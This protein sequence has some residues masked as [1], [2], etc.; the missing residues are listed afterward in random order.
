MYGTGINLSR[1]TLEDGRVFPS[2]EGKPLAWDFFL[3]D[4]WE[5]EKQGYPRAKA[6]LCE[7]SDDELRA[8]YRTYLKASFNQM[9]G[10]AAGK[11]LV[12]IEAEMNRRSEEHEEFRM[13][14]SHK[15][16]GNR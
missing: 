12:L 16:R 9:F 4:S 13:T 2:Y 10:H 11:M 5:E 15:D 1:V 8:S 3:Y 7:L 6:V 14:S